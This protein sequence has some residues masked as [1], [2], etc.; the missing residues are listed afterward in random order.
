MR[1]FF[2][3]KFLFNNNVAEIIIYYKEI[4]SNALCKNLFNIEAINISKDLIAYIN[5]KQYQCSELN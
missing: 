4:Y 2:R 3:F 5:V 1:I